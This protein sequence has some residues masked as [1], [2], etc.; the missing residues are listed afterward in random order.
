MSVSHALADLT[1]LNK[2]RLP[3]TV[4]IYL[5][6]LFELLGDKVEDYRIDAGIDGCHVDA[7]VVQH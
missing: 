7:E 4:V 1:Q 3:S 5:E 2:G 6:A